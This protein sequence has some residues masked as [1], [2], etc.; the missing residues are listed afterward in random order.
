MPITNY[1]KSHAKKVRMCSLIRILLCCVLSGM[2]TFTHAEVVPGGVY[3]TKLSASTTRVTYK[4]HPVL[5]V[6]RLAIVGIDIKAD[7]GDHEIT[8]FDE[9]DNATQRSFTVVAKQYPEQRL[10]IANPRMVNPNED[11]LKRIRSESAKMQT[12]YRSFSMIE[13]SLRPFLKPADGVTSSPFGHRCDGKNQLREDRR[14]LRSLEP[15]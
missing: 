12:Q 11:D 13:F 1:Q 8:L 3:T 4:N 9:A 10:T 6:D 2:C 5:I 7:P 14:W 15:N